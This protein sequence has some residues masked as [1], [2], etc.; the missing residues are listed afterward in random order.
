MKIIYCASVWNLSISNWFTLANSI[1]G[2]LISSQAMVAGI[3]RGNS[4]YQLA[5]E[6]LITE[7]RY[8]WST[9]KIR[10]CQCGLLLNPFEILKKKTPKSS[11]DFYCAY[12][13]HSRAVS[14][15]QPS[16]SHQSLYFQ[17]ETE[18]Q[19][20]T[21]SLKI[22]VCHSFS[23]GGTQTQRTGVCCEELTSS[24]FYRHYHFLWFL[25]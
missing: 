1:D 9:H 7:N 5:A 8:H 6:R 14:L 11:S 23:L 3:F 24:C 12:A 17:S 13:W 4:F 19:F 22:S 18:H 10:R 25:H 15:F 21:V 2:K 20:I 16:H